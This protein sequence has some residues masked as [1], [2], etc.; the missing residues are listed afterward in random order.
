MIRSKRRP[1]ISVVNRARRDGREARAAEHRGETARTQQP[2]NGL[3]M[4][5]WLRGYDS[6]EKHP[7]Q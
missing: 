6:A 7:P 1:P 2:T 3:L 4:V 5:A